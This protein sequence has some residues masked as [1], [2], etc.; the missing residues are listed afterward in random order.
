MSD[1]HCYT[2]EEFAESRKISV[3]TVYRHIRAGKIH[4]VERIG[5]LY[6]IWTRTPP[7]D[8]SR[9]DRTNSSALSS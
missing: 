1:R 9:H 4:G 3:R 6:R 7:R 8:T 5:R 2:P